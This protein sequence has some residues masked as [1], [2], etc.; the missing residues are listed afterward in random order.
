MGRPNIVRQAAF[1]CLLLTPLLAGLI[2]APPGFAAEGQDPPVFS[3]SNGQGQAWVSVRLARVRTGQSYTPL[4]VAVR[5]AGTTP[6]ILRRSSF[7]VVAADGE[8]LPMATARE[9]EEGYPMLL[10]DQTAVRF[11]GLPL[12][13]LLDLSNLEPSDFFPPAVGPD[14]AP[15]SDSVTLQPG[16]WTVDLLYFPRPPGLVEEQT[17]TIEIDGTGWAEPVEVP[18]HL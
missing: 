8:T 16:Q 7:R 11:T 17:I 3:G 2:Q 1:R 6:T 15:A 9:V 4:L 18:F 14:R 5:N 12:G 10:F 13:T